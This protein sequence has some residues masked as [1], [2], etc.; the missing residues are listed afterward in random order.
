MVDVDP[1]KVGQEIHGAPVVE[2]EAVGRFAMP[3]PESERGALV[4]AAVGQEGAREE[5]R[6]ACLDRGLEEGVDFVA[7]A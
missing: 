2:P 3:A 6:A 1:N 4:L 7:V 5:I